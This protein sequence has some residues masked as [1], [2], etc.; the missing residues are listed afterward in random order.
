MK[1]QNYK[2]AVPGIQ[3]MI[4]H[5]PQW[6][7]DLYVAASEVYDNL[8]EKELDP[9]FKQRYLDSLFIIYDLRIKNCGNE[10]YVLNRKAYSARKYYNTKKAKAAES[11]AIFDKTFDASGNDVLDNNLIGYID[12]MKI[13]DLPEDQVMKRYLKLMQ[14]IDFKMKKARTENHA[15]EVSKYTKVASYIEN[16]LPK[17]VNLD[18]SLLQ[19]YIEPVYKVDPTNLRI[20]RNVFDIVIE[21]KCPY[22]PTWFEAA[23][24]LHASSPNF[25]ITKELAVGYV[26]IKRFDK[27]ETF[28]A[29]AQVKAKTQS[30]KAW[31]DIIKG[32]MEYQKGN[33]PRARDLYKQALLVDLSA[34]APYERIGDLYLSSS[35]DCAKVT[36]TAEEKLIY[37]AAFQ[38]YLK[39]GNRD[40]MEQALAKYPTAEELKKVNWKSG[41]S[42]KIPCWIDETVTVKVKKEDFTSSAK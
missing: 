20:A 23:E 32:D 22:D 38:M 24:T 41:E 10:V 1:D 25:S 35:N 39:S 40:K 3:W 2:G 21:K 15:D 42:K 5:A 6:H 11:L 7:T 18:C 31:I 30:E 4:A 33:K 8:A 16:R 9:A 29:E 36:G 37:I 27:G 28:L 12:A 19:K 26:G 14:V 34:K 17:M 13:N